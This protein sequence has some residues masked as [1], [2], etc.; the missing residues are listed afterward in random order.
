MA[1][2]SSTKPAHIAALAAPLVVAVIAFGAATPWLSRQD[3]TVVLTITGILALAVVAWSVVFAVVIN[4]NLDEVQR[5]GERF[6][7]QWGVLAGGALVVALLVFPPFQSLVIASANRLGSG[8]PTTPD[9]ESVLLA[10]TFGVI[11]LVLAQ[12]LGAIIA[13]LIWSWRMAR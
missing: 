2:P 11:S 9:R 7:L 12:A 4:R 6:A 5:A 8:T 13:R 3:D 1:S 10:Y